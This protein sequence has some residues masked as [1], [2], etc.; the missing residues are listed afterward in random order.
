MMAVQICFRGFTLAVAGY[1]LNGRGSVYPSD[2]GSDTGS[3]K[4]CE[5]NDLNELH[6]IDKVRLCNVYVCDVATKVLEECNGRRSSL[7][8]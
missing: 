7:R 6:G 1:T 4:D 8:V 3:G 2:T 5:V